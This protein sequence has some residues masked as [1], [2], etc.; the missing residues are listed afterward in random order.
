MGGSYSIGEVAC[1]R[2]KHQTSSSGRE[3]WPKLDAVL[4]D[5][6]ISS[7]FIHFVTLVQKIILGAVKGGSTD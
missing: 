5:P 1:K 2:N 6:S 7:A 3:S 4:G